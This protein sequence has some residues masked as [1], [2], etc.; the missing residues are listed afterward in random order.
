MVFKMNTCDVVKYKL[1]IKIVKLNCIR[2]MVQ[3]SKCVGLHC[4]PS[5]KSYHGLTNP[6]VSCD[7][8]A[9]LSRANG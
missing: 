3:A 9:Q 7:R 2:N 8:L 6:R 5:H 1:S 4:T